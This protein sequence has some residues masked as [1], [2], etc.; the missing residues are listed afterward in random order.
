MTSSKDLKKWTKPKIVVKASGDEFF[1]N[2]AVCKGKDTFVLLYETNDSRWKPF[3]L[4]YMESTDLKNWQPIP[5]A[6]YGADKY[7]GG[8]AL[9]YESGWYYTLYLESIE[10]GYETRITRSQDLI[11]WEDAPQNQPFITF[12][13]THKNIPLINPAISE[14]NASDVEL[15]YFDGKT[16]L[17]FTGSDQTTAGDL[18][19]ATYEGTPAQL[20]AHFF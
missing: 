18:Q 7:V 17:Y 8:P 11:H 13:A 10:K 16:I 1:F 14:L 15:C 5:N 19:W 2:T 12:D 6:L 4:R 9:Y 20:F 3:T